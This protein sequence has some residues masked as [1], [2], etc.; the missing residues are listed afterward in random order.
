MLQVR[1][2]PLLAD[3]YGW[4]LRDGSGFTT[5]VDPAE[6]GPAAAAVEA[7]GGRLDMI[8]LTHH[9]ADHVAGT[10]ALRQR[11]GAKVAGAAADA[12]RLPSLDHALSPGQHFVL[13]SSRAE[14]IDT[15][16]HTRGHV[17]YFLAADSVLLVG[18]TIFSLGC[19]RLIEGTANEMFSSLKRLA[20]LPGESRVCCGH[21]YTLANARFALSLRPDDQALQARADEAR[22]SRAAGAP[23]VPTLIEEERR[24]NPFLLARDTAEF[25]RIRALKD[26]F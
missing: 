5:F 7:A 16:G 12:H 22:Q 8:L 11:F 6:D 26:R 10:D 13:G 18:D 20:A 2:V 25:A 14:V 3:N 9:H 24:L 15:P 1:P 21:E 23:T 4:L 17:A 19:G